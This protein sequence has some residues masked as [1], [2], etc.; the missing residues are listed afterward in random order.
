MA[1]SA[2]IYDPNGN[3]CMI[4]H[5]DNDAQLDDK[6]FNAPGYLQVRMDRATYNAL[7]KSAINID[8]LANYHDLNKLLVNEITS[9]DPVIGA[10]VS[11]KIEATDIKLIPPDPVEEEP[12]DGEVKI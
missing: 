6:A 10:K 9:K 11:Q 3:I 2:I 7:P 5:P 4:V 1:L 8:G 12:I